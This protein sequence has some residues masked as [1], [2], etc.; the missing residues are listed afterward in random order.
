M[1]TDCT[2]QVVTV[3]IKMN[4]YIIPVSDC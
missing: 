2:K 3:V 4:G 1:R